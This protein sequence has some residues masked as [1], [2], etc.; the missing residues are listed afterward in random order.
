M[1]KRAT[2]GADVLRDL[3]LGRRPMLSEAVALLIARI[4]VVV[5]GI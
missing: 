5:G 3:A 1:D 2:R 4:I